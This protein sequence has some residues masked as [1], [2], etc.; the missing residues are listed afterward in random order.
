VSWPANAGHPG[1]AFFFSKNIR[2]HPLMRV[3]HFPFFENK[4]DRPDGPAMTVHY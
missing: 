4:L 2:H 1:D 3:I